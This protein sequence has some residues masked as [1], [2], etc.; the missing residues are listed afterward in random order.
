MN[1]EC[2]YTW[3]KAKMKA[4]LANE[5]TD[6]EF[7][8]LL[9]NVSMSSKEREKMAG[10]YLDEELFHYTAN[11][12]WESYGWLDCFKNAAKRDNGSW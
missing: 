7:D 2:R 11:K 12:E 1:R 4:L 5:M 9:D 6:A 8:V 3:Y 10:R